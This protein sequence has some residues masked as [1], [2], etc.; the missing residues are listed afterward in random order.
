MKNARRSE[1]ER[2]RRLGFP[3]K[4]RRRKR[5]PLKWRKM[6]GGENS[7]A[8]EATRTQKVAN[9]IENAVTF[10]VPLALCVSAKN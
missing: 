8:A 5:N 10:L 3:I 6:T 2:E 1:R 4:Q 7:R 9:I